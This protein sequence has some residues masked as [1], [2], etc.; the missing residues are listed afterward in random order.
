M[1]QH[2][3][4]HDGKVAV[5]GDVYWLPIDASTPRNVKVLAISRE[6]AGVLSVSEIRTNETWWTHWH[7]L[8]RFKAEESKP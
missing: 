6:S 2:H 4:N 7:P 3:I 8:P 1:S 5:A